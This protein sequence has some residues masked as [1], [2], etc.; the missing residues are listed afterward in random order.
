[1]TVQPSHWW[2]EPLRI[3]DYVNAAELDTADFRAYVALCR[4]LH[5]NAVH[6][7]A[8]DCMHGGVD[9]NAFYFR[10]R[11]AK[12][13][14]RDVLAEALPLL[15]AA[16]IRVIVYT[17]G[18][19]FPKAFGDQHPDWWVIKA[20]GS[21]VENLYG[22]NDLTFCLN[23]PWRVWSHDIVADLCAY[24]IDGVLF[25]GPVVFTGRGGCYCAACRSKFRALYGRELSTW[26]RKKDPENWRLF[27][28]FA[29]RSVQ[30][31]Y[32]EAYALA[33]GLRPE[34]MVYLNGCNEFEAGW[35]CGR[36]NR[37]LMPYQDM[38]AAEG[39]FH[40]SRLLKNKWHTPMAAK[41]YVTQAGGK[42]AVNA[43][44]SAFGPWRA[45]TLSAPEMRVLLAEAS[46]GVNPYMAFFSPAGLSPG[47]LAAGEVLG[48]LE[49]HERYYRQTR[50]LA[51]VALVYGSQTVDFYRGGADVPRIDLSGIAAQ[52]TEELT[53]FNRSFAGY[54]DLLVRTRVPFD[55][56]DEQVLTDSDLSRYALL[57]LPN[58]A[59]LS[60]RQCDA[61]ADYVR[62]GGRI[63][64]EFETAHYDEAGMRR[65]GF[66]VGDL[67]GVASAGEV[68]GP[69]AQDF[70][71][72]LDPTSPHLAELEQA[73]FPAPRYTLKV[74]GCGGTTLVA[75]GK[76]LAS[77]IVS[78][79]PVSDEPLLVRHAVGRGVSFYFT[80]LVGDH[81]GECELQPYLRLLRGILRQE[82]RS[83]VEVT[84]APHLLHVNLRANAQ[85]DTL[86][87]LVNYEI[88][89]VDSVIPAADLRIALRTGGP[90]QSVRALRLERELPFTA[91]D[92]GVAFTLP[93][94]E[95]YE[96]VAIEPRQACPPQ[97]VE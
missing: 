53:A 17:D 96:V 10:C 44:S 24:D 73:L 18:H 21:R 43:V 22:T 26:D 2:G 91:A 55:V 20:D 27:A 84:G 90:V 46:T 88:G 58:C 60:D 48:F 6:F 97:F 33:K 11:H 14:N 23:S 75:L 16:G 71:H 51:N 9:E 3:L 29:Q 85:G 87:H 13:Q 78:D 5:V 34:A 25:D 67:F 19:W 64:A 1:M 76:P 37:P 12:R 41:L 4:R 77:N 32:R 92:G 94:L 89:P 42:P 68:F 7:H 72:A 69:R 80:G 40:Y 95:E 82:V 30:D 66:G 49:Q 31:Y 65:A 54:F 93:R 70:A 15:H 52:S 79:Y 28:D 50:S 8:M 63:V 35:Y 57:V 38:L 83:P 45:H 59:C 39:G 81:Y 86:L 61:L 62:R 74:T 47:V 56:I 36:Q